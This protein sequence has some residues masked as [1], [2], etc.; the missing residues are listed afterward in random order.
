MKTTKTEDL[1]S[2]KG[3]VVLLDQLKG[4]LVNE[5]EFEIAVEA[6]TLIDSLKRRY[7]L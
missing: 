5:Q 4:F 3:F 2:L 6:R 1:D 7:R